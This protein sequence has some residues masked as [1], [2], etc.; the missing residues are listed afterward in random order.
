MKILFTGMGSHHCKR[1]VNN[2]FFKLLSDS[3]SE[4][5]DVVWSS[6]SM[7]WKKEDLEKYDQIFFGLLPP[8]SLSANKI[9]GS[10]NVLGLLFDSP[11]LKLVVDSPQIW[12]YKNSI[13]AVAKNPG[14]L[15]SSFYSKREG[16]E[17]ANRN[18]SIVEK[19]AAHMLVS[20]WPTIVYPEL[21]WN[22]DEKISSLFGFSN[23]KNI[24]GINLDPLYIDPEPSRIGR[25]DYWAVENQKS[26]WLESL[27]KSIVFPQEPTKI[28][29]KTD[30][31][32]ALEVIRNSVG[33]ILP[34]QERNSTTWW[35]YR[36]VQAMNTSTPIATYWPDTQLFSSSWSM[37]AYQIEDMSSSQR[38]ILASTQR[39]VYLEALPN[40]SETKEKLNSLV[41]D[42]SKERI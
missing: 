37:L 11:K 32:Y 34:P 41:V 14:I 40:A 30:D 38:Q 33:L 4:Y 18:K 15:F 24:I 9:Y 27:K 39:N 25:R 8:T 29:K 35:N 17:A 42:S 13:S 6:P 19:V 36:L 23:S 16:Y 3:L 2:S 5:H 28:G 26:S 7:S 12:Q 22:S 21:P 31:A 10:L 1:P 20:N